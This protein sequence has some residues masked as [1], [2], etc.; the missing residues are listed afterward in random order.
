MR[1][2]AF[3]PDDHTTLRKSGI[4]GT[5]IGAIVGL[6]P[7]RTGFDVWCEKKGLVENLPPTIRQRVG[8]AVEPIIRD[9]YQTLTGRELAEKTC[10]RHPE[11]PWMVGEIDSYVIPTDDDRGVD[12]KNVSLWATSTEP[13]GQWGIEGTDQV[14]AYNLVQAAW[15]QAITDTQWWDIVPLRNERLQIYT[16]QRDAELEGLLIAAAAQF[17]RDY[18]DADQAP[19]L[20]FVTDLT[21]AYLRQRYAAHDAALVEAPAH[22]L[23]W[24]TDRKRLKDQRASVESQLE[25]VEFLLKDACG[26]HAGL[27][28]P[29]GS[30]FTWKKTRESQAVDWH[31]LAQCL[32]PDPEL[33]QHF[34]RTKPGFRRIHVR[35]GA[36]P[37]ED[38]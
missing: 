28:F 20:T 21:R 8:L 17:R 29:D 2:D 16:I 3:V 31:A 4:S 6:S 9:I 35:Y 38:T 5:D 15:Y 10:V 30:C 36:G 22:A 32:H 18:L 33:I 37:E 25:R 14:P 13:L 26:D 12:Y 11:R 27:R 19:P 24:L 34:T 1:P 23:E 7:W